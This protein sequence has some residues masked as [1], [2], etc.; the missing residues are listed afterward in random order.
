MSYCITEVK[1]AKQAYH[2]QYVN[3]F[4]FKYFCKSAECDA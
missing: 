1:N 2:I 4:V 3:L